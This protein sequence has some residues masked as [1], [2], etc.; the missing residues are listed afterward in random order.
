MS[1]YR[2]LKYF[3]VHTLMLTNKE[4]QRLIESG[5]IEID[6]HKVFDNCFLEESSEINVDGVIKRPKKEFVYFKFNKPSGYESTLNNTIEANLSG[7]FAGHSDLAIAGRLDKFS[8]GLLLVSN[9][10]KW[11]EKLC[12][13]KFEKEKEYLV[14]LAPYPD[15]DFATAFSQGVTIGTYLTAPCFCEVLKG[16]QIRVILKEG[17]NRQIRRMCKKLGY[18]VLELKRVRMDSIILD[19]LNEGEKIHLFENQ[20]FKT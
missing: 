19:D 6:G 11:V 16:N 13:P 5:L 18:D 14:T 2:R 20:I 1:F 10:G 8:Q 12:N 4:A 15:Q 3:L 7:F 17:K 9:D